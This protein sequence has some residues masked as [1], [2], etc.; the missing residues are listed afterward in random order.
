M[1]LTLVEPYTVYMKKLGQFFFHNYFL[2][3][4]ILRIKIAIGHWTLSDK[5]GYMS[6][7]LISKPDILPCTLSLSVIYGKS[8][9]WKLV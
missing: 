7:P 1:P 3:C 2:T 5:K 6:S 9:E 4:L 8:F